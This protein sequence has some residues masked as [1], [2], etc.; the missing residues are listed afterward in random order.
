MYKFLAKNGQL[1]AFALGAFITVVFLI[2]V[3]TGLEGFLSLSKEEQSTTG[4]FN[5]GLVATI[6]LAIAGLAAAI[7][8]GLFQAI[9]NP[10]GSI[11][12]I[13]AIVA[14]LV[15]FF[16]G[17]AIMGTDDA[18]IQKTIDTFNITDGQSGFIAGAI[19]TGLALAVLALVALALSEV[20]NFFK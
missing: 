14:L 8:F 4:I 16:V 3:F 18:A 7:G 1:I 17:R 5:I 9:S 20:R 10:K 12:G 15:I 19:S 11:Y 13:G 2:S 6:F